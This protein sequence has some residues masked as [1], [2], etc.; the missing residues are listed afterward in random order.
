MITIDQ[1][2]E[3]IKDGKLQELQSAVNQQAELVRTTTSMGVSLL[4]FAAYCGSNGAIALLRPLS[5]PISYYEAASIGARD[6]I[7]E[8]LRSEEPLLNAPGPDGFTALGLASFFGHHDVATLLLKHSADPNV[9]A[10]NSIG[11][12]PIHSACAVSNYEIA[13]LLLEAGASPNVKQQRD[14]TPLHSAAHNGQRELAELLLSFSANRTA[15]TTAGQTPA[16]M[17]DDAGFE[18][19]AVWLRS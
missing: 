8:W 9:P 11:V 3:L 12:Y 19:L 1:A 16:D 5:E 6:V 13:K 14:I 7:E 2:C 18:E 4:Q 10:A 15:K 17:A